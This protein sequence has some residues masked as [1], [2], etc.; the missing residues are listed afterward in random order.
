MDGEEQVG[1]CIIAPPKSDAIVGTGFLLAFHK[2]LIVDV[3]NG[4]AE[5]AISGYISNDEGTA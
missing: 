1:M 2:K 5:L 3:T 4:Y